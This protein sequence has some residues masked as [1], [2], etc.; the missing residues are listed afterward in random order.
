MSESGNKIGCQGRTSPTVPLVSL[1][2]NDDSSAR[3]G[4]QRDKSSAWKTGR[5]YFARTAS[6]DWNTMEAVRIYVDE[7]QMPFGAALERLRSDLNDLASKRTSII[8][9]IERMFNDLEVTTAYF[10]LR[11]VYT[12]ISPCLISFLKNLD[13]P[14]RKCL[15]SE[16]WRMSGT[17]MAMFPKTTICTVQSKTRVY[18]RSGGKTYRLMRSLVEKQT[19]KD[20]QIM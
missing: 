14:I 3:K 19:I 18:K 10:L 16:K 9:P 12:L 15:V 6:K 11:V 5:D 20:M 2:M 13:N 7:L 1:E 17:A 8:H 4:K